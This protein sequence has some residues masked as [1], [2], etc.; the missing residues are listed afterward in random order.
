[1]L[2]RL[3]Q[4]IRHC[5]SC[6]L[7]GRSLPTAGRQSPKVKHDFEEITLHSNACKLI[8]S[9]QSCNTVLHILILF[10]G[11]IFRNGSNGFLIFVCVLIQRHE[12]TFLKHL[13]PDSMK[14]F[15]ATDKQE[16]YYPFVERSRTIFLILFVAS[17]VMQLVL[18]FFFK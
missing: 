6:I 3:H 15:R 18:F 13:I 8:C 11:H 12:N 14:L 5:E 7:A 9:S 1:L 17:S 10:S 16:P 4:A 2:Q